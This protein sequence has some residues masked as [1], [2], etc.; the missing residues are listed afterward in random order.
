MK[1][2][3]VVLLLAGALQAQGVLVVD[4]SG[5]VKRAEGPA[6]V[7]YDE[8]GAGQGLVL[9]KGAI[10]ELMGLQGGETWRFQGPGR[11]LLKGGLLQGLKPVSVRKVAAALQGATGFRP[12]SYGQAG[13]VMMEKSAKHFGDG[14]SMPRTRMVAVLSPSTRLAWAPGTPGTTFTFELR[15]DAGVVAMVVTERPEIRLPEGVAL[16]SGRTYTWTVTA[17][18]RDLLAPPRSGRIRLA[19]PELRARMAAVRPSAEATF[20]ERLLYAALLAQE[21]LDHDAREAWV[22]LAR[23][24]PE[25]PV[26]R[27]LAE[28]DPES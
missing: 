7:L 27:R 14:P 6:V 4:V 22:G 25:D 20:S 5:S 13:V 28:P 9:E 1:E 3:V 23:E 10:L 16:A 2:T 12:G 19:T 21:G 24:R 8:L 18:P 17:T 11:L 15:G 26:L